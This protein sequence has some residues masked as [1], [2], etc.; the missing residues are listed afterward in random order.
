MINLNNMKLIS[1]ITAFTLIGCGSV[2]KTNTETEISVEDKS[3][4]VTDLFRH[5]NSFTLEPINLDKPILIG[6]DTVYNTRVIYNNTK[7]TIKEVEKKDITSDLKQ[8][9][10]TKDKDYS[11]V[12]ESLANR[13]IWLIAILFIISIISKRINPLK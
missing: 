11:Q 13:L 5:S 7:E 2:K 12:I 10:R 3:E 9:E 8:E 6:K 4:K 1:I